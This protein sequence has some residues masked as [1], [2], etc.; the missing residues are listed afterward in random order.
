MVVGG[1][2]A[3]RL[4]P[5]FVER[6]EEA[7]L[8]EVFPRSPDLRVVPAALGDQGGSIGAAL[9]AA[10]RIGAEQVQG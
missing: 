10:E 6:V 3:D 8:A 9:L 4:G 2:L 7:C 5:T 1:G